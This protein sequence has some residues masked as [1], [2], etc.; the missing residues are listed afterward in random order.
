MTYSP[1]FIFRKRTTAATY[2]LANLLYMV[3]TIR[4]N[5]ATDSTTANSLSS[6]NVSELG[7][8]SKIQIQVY[9]SIHLY[10]SS[11]LTKYVVDSAGCWRQCAARGVLTVHTRIVFISFSAV[12]W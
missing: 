4:S 12:L 9:T 3:M 6:L 11:Q 2:D 5:R 7:V 10:I 1:L 8:E